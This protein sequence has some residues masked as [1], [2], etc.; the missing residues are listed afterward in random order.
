M[1]GKITM[2]PSWTLE[3]GKLPVENPLT[4]LVVGFFASLLIKDETWQL[5]KNK[6]PLGKFLQK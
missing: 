1:I 6:L 5:I 2:S 3:L 4:P